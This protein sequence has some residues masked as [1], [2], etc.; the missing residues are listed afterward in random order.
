MRCITLLEESGKHTLTPAYHPQAIPVERK[1]RDLKTRL[2]IFVA[3]EHSS[4]TEKLLTIRFA[5]NEA[6]QDKLSYNLVA[7]AAPSDLSKTMTTL[8][9]G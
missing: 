8:C 6:Q 5:I 4:W 2:A 7:S 9:Q 1:N 3:N